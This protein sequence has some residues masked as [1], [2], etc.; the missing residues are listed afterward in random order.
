MNILENIRRIGIFMIAAQTVLHFAAGKQYE[1]YL[2]IIAGVI[3]LLQFL[4]PFTSS[5]DDF[6]VRWQSEIE[7]MEKQVEEQ[8]ERQAKRQSDVLQAV[9]GTVEPM[10]TVVLK[11]I[12]GEVKKRLNDVAADNGCTVTDVAIDL[13]QINSESDTMAGEGNRSWV[14]RSVKVTVQS[15]EQDGYPDADDDGIIRIAEIAVGR[16]TEADTGQSEGQDPEY[17]VRCREYRHLF[18]QTLGMEDDKVEVIYRG[19]R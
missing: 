4:S 3:I 11:Q 16:E 18:A 6:A 8:M 10:E 5:A 15:V 13:E 17:E 1:K 7:Q 2:K 12:E 19:K 14:F 9:S